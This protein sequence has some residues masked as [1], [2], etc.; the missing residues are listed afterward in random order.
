MQALILVSSMPPT[1]A[2]LM[3]SSSLVSRGKST[4]TH[5]KRDCGRLNDVD[6]N[7]QTSLAHFTNPAM[8]NVR[9]EREDFIASPLFSYLIEAGFPLG[10]VERLQ[11]VDQQRPLEVGEGLHAN[12]SSGVTAQP[13]DSWSGHRYNRHEL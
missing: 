7:I 12:L 9:A 3:L 10:G 4:Y 13:S 5:K 2:G 1:S 6:N 11:I 8:C